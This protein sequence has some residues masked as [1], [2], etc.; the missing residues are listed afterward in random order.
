MMR[1]LLSDHLHHYNENNP[2][3]RVRVEALSPRRDQ[4]NDNEPY[5]LKTNNPQ[6]PELPRGSGISGDL[7]LAPPPTNART[8]N[9]S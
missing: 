6:T 2:Q 5:R 1:T 9:P 8:S 7:T 4:V 3:N